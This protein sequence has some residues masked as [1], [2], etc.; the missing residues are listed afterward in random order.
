MTMDAEYVQAQ[1]KERGP[2]LPLSKVKRIGKVD[3]ESMVTSNMG[4]VAVAFAAEYFVQ[5]FV[6]QALLNSQLNKRKKKANASRLTYDDLLECVRNRDDFVFLEDVI[7]RK[8]AEVTRK[9]KG[10]AEEVEEELQEAEQEEEMQEEAQDEKEMQE[11]AQDEKEMQ[12]EEQEMHREVVQKDRL[13]KVNVKKAS[14]SARSVLSAFK[15]GAADEDTEMKDV[16]EEQDA[17]QDKEDQDVDIIDEEDEDEEEID[18]EVQTQLEEVAKMDV[19][20]D[21]EG[22]ENNDTDYDEDAPEEVEDVDYSRR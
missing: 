1:L 2:R 17:D 3:Q 22:N 4:Y 6:E 19:V 11:E 20:E 12:G 18:P 7:R 15:Y 21:L 10:I 9:T 14:D 5:T 16:A 8:P 13:S